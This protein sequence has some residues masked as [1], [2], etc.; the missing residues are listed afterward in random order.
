MQNPEP[1][2]ITADD[3]RKAVAVVMYILENGSE[4]QQLEA[5]TVLIQ[6]DAQNQADELARRPWLDKTSNN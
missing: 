6:M 4:E 2:P 1:F 3:R 5:C